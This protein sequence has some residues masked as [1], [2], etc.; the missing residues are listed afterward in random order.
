VTHGEADYNFQNAPYYEGYLEQWQSDFQNDVDAIAGTSATLPMFISQMN[1]GY[2]G[3]LVRLVKEASALTNLM[4]PEELRDW[5]REA[6]SHRSATGKTIVFTLQKPLAEVS[7]R[8][9]G[10]IGSAGK[11]TSHKFWREW[12]RCLQNG[13]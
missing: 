10:P 12:V 4:A 2:S 1:A 13:S 5:M 9:T 7:A 11:E 3:E 8:P 6:L